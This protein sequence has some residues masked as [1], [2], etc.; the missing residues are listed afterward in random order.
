MYAKKM[1]SVIG[2]I[3]HV[4]TSETQSNGTVPMQKP[5][6]SNEHNEYNQKVIRQ[7]RK[8][9][10]HNLS[11]VHY[12][13]STGKCFVP[14]GGRGMCVNGEEEIEEFIDKWVTEAY[15]G[16]WFSFSDT[17]ENYK[18]GVVDIDF[19]HLDMSDREKKRV[20]RSC[21]RLQAAG[22]PTLIQ[23]TG[24]GYHVWF[25]RKQDQLNDCHVMNNS[26]ARALGNIPDAMSTRPAKEEQKQS[27]R[28]LFTSNWKHSECHV[29][30][31]ASIQA[32]LTARRRRGHG[33]STVPGM[34]LLV[35]H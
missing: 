1:E 8:T 12:S 16:L 33:V 18:A 5:T 17:G 4:R 25:G 26:I 6:T 23:F 28:V 30:D 11:V 19:H 21:K 10:Y 13:T 27:Q 32:Q 20:T 34:A 3:Y 35:C 22:Y 29:G 14:T 9:M 15:R 2:Q 24:H 7:L 31:T